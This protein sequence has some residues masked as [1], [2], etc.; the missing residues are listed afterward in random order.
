LKA[1]EEDELKWFV[2]LTW[3]RQSEAPAGFE[4]TEPKDWISPND[5]SK[6][7]NIEISPE[8]WIIFNN[9]ETGVSIMVLSDSIIVLR[10]KICYDGKRV[11][12]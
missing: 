2:P 9:Q 8:E 3:T 12:N 4:S 6:V 5:T 11:T 10:G 7:L 1:N